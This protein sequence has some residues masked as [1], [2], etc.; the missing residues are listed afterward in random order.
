M[1]RILLKERAFGRHNRIKSF[2]FYYEM[3]EILLLDEQTASRGGR[4]T[5]DHEV[6]HCKHFSGTRTPFIEVPD[7]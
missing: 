1:Y 5:Q 2:T 7:I 6:E 4:F 3:Q